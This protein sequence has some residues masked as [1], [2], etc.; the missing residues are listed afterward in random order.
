[1]RALLLRAQ[2]GDQTVLP[3]L[4]EL[5]DNR[6]E[7]WRQ[8][9]DLADHARDALLRLAGGQSLLFRES[10]VRRMEELRAELAGPEPSPLEK[11]LVERIVLCWAQSYA[12]DVSATEQTR[13]GSPDSS[14]ALKRQTAA[15]NRYLSAIRQLATVRR[16]LREAP[17]PLQLLRMPV[18]ETG[19]AAATRCRGTNGVGAAGVLN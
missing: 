6:P 4:R 11:L 3:Q 15:Q 7:L 13:G 2:Q 18:E 10:V 1:M 17:S 19:G 8:F 9:G 16:L 5:L 14:L 12:A